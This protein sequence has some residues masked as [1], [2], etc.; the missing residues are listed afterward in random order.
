[1]GEICDGGFL[2]WDLL[3]ITK[4]FNIEY[5]DI[6]RKKHLMTFLKEKAQVCGIYEANS[7]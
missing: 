2:G 5:F 7:D 1:M 3:K 4:L 6:K